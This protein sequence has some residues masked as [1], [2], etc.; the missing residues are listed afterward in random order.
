MNCHE[1]FERL[2]PL[3][4]EILVSKHFHRDAPNF[5][6]DLI[7]DCSHQYFTRLHKFEETIGGNHIFR[8]IKGHSHIVYAIDKQGRLIFLRA[9]H[10]FNAYKKFLSDKKMILSMIESFLLNH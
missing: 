3:V 7:V 6:I 9:F 5:N 1:Y 4:K 2:R 10:N 8:A